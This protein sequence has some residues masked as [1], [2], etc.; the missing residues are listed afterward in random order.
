[1]IGYAGRLVDDSKVSEGNPKYLLP[2]TRER[3]GIVYEFR[4]SLF[5]YNGHRLTQSVEKIIIV[6]GFMSLWWLW[7]A[8]ITNVVALVG[9][10]CNAEQAQLIVQRV[11]GDGRIW[12]MSDGDEA[13]EQSATSLLV[14]I[15]PHRFT[16]W[17]RLK[18]G[19]QPTEYPPAELRR[20]LAE[21]LV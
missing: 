16:R 18:T 6:E 12:I 21:D 7:Q 15:T 1:M 10:T 4:K 2:G 8:G 17:V 11:Q 20:L 5:L 13:G 9:T 19:R 14:Q 3:G